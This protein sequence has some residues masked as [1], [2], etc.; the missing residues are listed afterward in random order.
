MVEALMREA[1]W[2]HA[3]QGIS[4]RAVEHLSGRGLASRQSGVCDAFC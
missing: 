3:I 1:F 4:F 2:A